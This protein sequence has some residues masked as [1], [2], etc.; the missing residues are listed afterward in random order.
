[1]TRKGLVLRRVPLSLL[2]AEIRRVE[3]NDADPS[4]N[5]GHWRLARKYL[6]RLRV[7]R[8]LLGGVARRDVMR[9]LGV[10]RSTLYRCVRLWNEGG[11]ERLAPVPHTGRHPK[12]GREGL[13]RLDRDLQ[14]PPTDFGFRED[15]W[16]TRLVMILIAERYGVRY[17]VSSVYKL[18]RR[19]G[20]GPRTPYPEDPRGDP[21]EEA[22]FREK[23]LPAL[24]K[25]EEAGERG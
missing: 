2:D 25:K 24:I 19:L 5:P 17:H 11:F 8:L 6:R 16:S 9:M 7:V 3:E 1:M 4:K 10:S 23:V 14:R 20:Y 21:G 18:M 12:I 15:A 13:Q 22:F